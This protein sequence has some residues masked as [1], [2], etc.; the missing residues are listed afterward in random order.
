MDSIDR[1]TTFCTRHPI[2]ILAM[3]TVLTL[4]LGLQIPQI[5]ID[6]DP[7]NMLSEDEFVRVFHNQVK[8]D[9]SLHDMLVLGVVN[10][11][12]ADG[13]FN[14]NTLKRVFE[15]TRK[16]QTIDGVIGVDLLA[17]STVD[18]IRQAGPGTVR[19][20]WLMKTPPA[21]RAEALAIR[22]R[23][24]ANPMLDGTL[25]SEDGKALCLYIPLQSKAISYRVAEEIR[26]SLRGIDGMERYY[27]TGLPVA[28]N[29]FGIEMFKQMAI[30][31]PLAGLLIVLLMWV[32]FK[33]FLL[34]MS[35]MMV[36]MATVISTMGLLIG[37]GF[38]V[39]IMSSMIPIFLMPIAVVDSIHI[40]SEFFDRYPQV[41][42]RRETIRV[43]MGK[44]WYP[45]LFT[46]LTSAAGFASLAFTPNPPVRI[47]GLF[48][49]FGIMLAWMLTMTVIPAYIM[50]L[51]ESSVIKADRNQ[52]PSSLPPRLDRALTAVGRWT[53]RGSKPI[54]VS[55]VLVL[56]VSVVGISQIV[57]NDNP[58]KWFERTHPIRIADR[59]LNAHFG[60][61]YMAYLV[62]EP[63]REVAGFQAVIDGIR[64][65]LDLR[66]EALKA[67]LPGLEHAKPKALALL[68]G[69]AEGQMSGGEPSV[70]SLFDTLEAAATRET[71]SDDR[72]QAEA[73]DELAFFFS[74]QRVAAQ[75]FKR[76]DVLS[77]LEQLETRLMET[78][79]VGKV[80]SLVDV[81]KKVH[82][83]L[84]EG[85][86]EY[87]VIPSTAPAV[88]QVLMAYQS[89]H[90]PD[91]LW[92]V[93]T[94][95]YQKANLWIQL[96]SGDNKD[97][98]PVL[99]AVRQ[100]FEQ[101]PPPI[102]LEY[103][104]AGLTYL[105]VIWQEKM[106]QGMVRALCGSFVIVLLMATVLFRSPLYGLLCMFPLTVTIALIYGLIGFAG[107]DYD[108]PVA[109]LSS[110][111][112]G[113]SVDFAIHF[114]QRSRMAYLQAGGSWEQAALHMFGEPARAISRNIL[115]I[116]V[117]FTP[118]LMAPLVPYKTVGFFLA[119]IM[120]LSGVGTLILLP[121]V[122]KHLQK[123]LF[124]GEGFGAHL[125]HPAVCVALTVVTVIG[126]SYGL[127][128][129]GVGGWQ[130][131]VGI[132]VLGLIG[133]VL[134]CRSLSQ[135][136]VRKE[137]L[138]H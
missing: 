128:H 91:D 46:S 82:Y 69:A 105:N 87:Q 66:V 32:V 57:I 61:T 110:M 17:P 18:D 6:T 43:V 132:I 65:A 15:L 7:E 76:P 26:D 93:V 95:D 129:I 47:F 123:P 101:H 118:L 96:T 109:V 21:T 49:A 90:D 116:A 81:V 55:A 83:E 2:A 73:W 138:I 67:D 120:I 78:G 127:Y 56:G 137:K 130:M 124:Q 126:L 28:E 25:L 131:L 71:A 51:R 133:T 8:R 19:F 112:L 52:D 29:T 36:A 44:L 114:L 30:S 98:E 117:G 23:A 88:A 89:S 135:R 37:M 48:V 16:I 79:A 92:H 97:L 111:T 108:M 39:H 113:L 58:V 119:G 9:F 60:G 38:P 102:P 136:E 1:Y 62:I 20:V 33:R 53:Y 42:D 74:E 35:A 100:F 121:A 27:L 14:P 22:D 86:K 5:T 115:V 31:A 13:V 107:K 122:I 125:C 104:W 10:E 85:N 134:L 77:F 64:N 54:L 75:P 11:G 80:T 45:M 63:P 24:R 99:L 12:H 103:H 50:I 40:L 4:V 59:I 3:V 70:P 68:D 41:Q 72:D 94:P 106:V 34:I 84:R